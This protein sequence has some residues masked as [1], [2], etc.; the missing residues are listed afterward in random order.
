MVSGISGHLQA[1]HNE[2]TRN[3]GSM[4]LDCWGLVLLLQHYGN[5][6][7]TLTTVMRPPTSM[8]FHMNGRLAAHTFSRTGS[9]TFPCGLV[10]VTLDATPSPI[11]VFLVDAAR[12]T[13]C[14]QQHTRSQLDRGA[15]NVNASAT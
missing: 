10:N 14:L 11:G 12:H 8:V 3:E 1:P 5:L 15:V 13:A 9:K 7:E 4:L 6:P 2:S